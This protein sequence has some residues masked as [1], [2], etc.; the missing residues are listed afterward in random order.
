MFTENL[1]SVPSNPYTNKNK[2]VNKIQIVV[3][4]VM[5]NSTITAF[6]GDQYNS[7]M[8]TFNLADTNFIRSAGKSDCFI[9]ANP[10]TEAE[11]CSFGKSHTVEEWSYD[12]N[13]FKNQCKP[14]HDKVD[15]EQEME[16]KLEEK[17]NK[18]K[19]QV[20]LDTEEKAKKRMQHKEQEELQQE[21]KQASQV[22]LKAIAKE[23]DIEAMIKEEELEREI[24]HEK[25]L[26]EKVEQEKKKT[27]SITRAIKEKELAN[28][29]NLR[30]QQTKQEIKTIKEQAV[31]Q[32]N[33]KR[34]ELKKK[35]KEL[36]E[37][38]K[39]R[40]L[41]IAN[42][43]QMVRQ[44]LNKTMKNAYRKG[45]REHCKIT[46]EAEKKNYCSAN[47]DDVSEF[48]DCMSE[49]FCYSCCGNE[50]GEMNM[51]ERTQCIEEICDAPLKQDPPKPV[52]EITGQWIWVKENN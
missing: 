11:F 40:E 29:F 4:V 51:E 37:K 46:N 47:L 25:V 8:V 30:A 7:Q 34:I 49:N 17:L 36:R 10:K 13:Q 3:R 24:E 18:E 15:F 42:D 45:N 9:L 52:P 32:V 5:N 21:V 28:Q 16:R 19:Q 14:T 50:F 35:I 27:E 12:F 22:A 44:S 39:A 1:D 33:V 41:Q 43:L 23:L 38:A 2:K 48:A 26:E 20:L 6:K 31:E